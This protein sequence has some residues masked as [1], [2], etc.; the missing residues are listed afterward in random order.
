MN[1]IHN[2]MHG[3]FRELS[4]IAEKIA[5][6]KKTGKRVPDDLTDRQNEVQLKLNMLGVRVETGQCCRMQCRVVVAETIIIRM[7]CCSDYEL[8]CLQ[9]NCESYNN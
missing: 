6:L 1:A 5:E 9:L 7:Y 8:S 3:I 4:N 2:L